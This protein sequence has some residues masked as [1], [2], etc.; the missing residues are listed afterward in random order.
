MAD[1][2]TGDRDADQARRLC[3][4]AHQAAGR[5]RCRGERHPA[6]SSSSAFRARSNVPVDKLPDAAPDYV[7]SARTRSRRHGGA[8]R[9]C[10]QGDA[11]CDCCGR[12]AVRRSSAGRPGPA[13]RRR[14][15]SMWCRNLPNAR[16]R[17]REDSAPAAK[18]RRTRKCRRRS[19]CARRC[20]R[21]SRATSSNCPTAS[22]SRPISDKDKLSLM[23]DAALA[24][25][26][27]DAKIGAA[28]NVASIEQKIERTSLDGRV[29]R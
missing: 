15:R 9:A 28:P 16:A 12:A 2:V 25:D 27:A 5:C 29:R 8:A 23:F 6:R 21:P 7:G 4:P 11:E 18:P 14:C 19:A 26:L 24:F 20:S 3:A 1:A 10:A 22:A 17:R 13:S